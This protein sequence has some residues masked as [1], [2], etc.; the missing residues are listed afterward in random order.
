MGI[1]D[2]IR[3]LGDTDSLKENRDLNFSSG[4]GYIQHSPELVE[5]LAVAICKK[6]SCGLKDL[7]NILIIDQLIEE[8]LLVEYLVIIVVMI[9]I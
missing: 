3:I 2:I 6:L 7:I 1:Q 8:V 9:K 5:Q 4:G